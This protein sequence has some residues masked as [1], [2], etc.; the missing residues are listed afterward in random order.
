MTSAALIFSDPERIEQLLCLGDHLSHIYN[1][2]SRKFFNL[3]REDVF[4][5]RTAA[6]GVRFL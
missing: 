1:A 2:E 5:N 4:R 6:Y 3:T